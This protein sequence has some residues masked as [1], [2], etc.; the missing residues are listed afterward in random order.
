MIK[1][2]PSNSIKNNGVAKLWENLIDQFMSNNVYNYCSAELAITI[3][4]IDGLVKNM[5]NPNMVE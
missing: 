1:A 4:T 3:L 5:Q 2:F